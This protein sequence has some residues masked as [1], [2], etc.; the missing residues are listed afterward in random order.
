MKAR[1]KLDVRSFKS[2]QDS[3]RGQFILQ[4]WRC[5]D[6]TIQL[7][8]FDGNDVLDVSNFDTIYLSIR[9]LVD[10]KP[11]SGGEPALILKSTSDIDTTMTA[12][13]WERG[14]DQNAELSFAYDETSLNAG[15]YWISFWAVTEDNETITLGAGVCKINENG[16]ISTVPPDP[17]VMYYTAEETDDLLGNYA[18]KADVEEAFSSYYSKDEADARFE[19]IGGS[20]GSLDDYYTK[21]EADSRFEPLGGS[22]GALDNYYTKDETDSAISVFVGASLEDFYDKDETNSA[23]SDEVGSA[24]TNYYDKD[25]ADSRF[26]PIGG[27]GGV[28]PTSKGTIAI[29]DGSSTQILDAGTSNQVLV[30]DPSAIY[31]AK[32]GDYPWQ[33]IAKYDIDSNTDTITFEKIFNP[34]KFFHYKITC[35]FVRLNTV[36]NRLCMQYGYDSEGTTTWIDSKSEYNSSVADLAGTVAHYESYKW[37]HPFHPVGSDSTSYRNNGGDLYGEFDIWNSGS[38]SSWMHARCQMSS[39]RIYNG[40]LICVNG[41][42]SYHFKNEGQYSVNSVRF[43][44]FAVVTPSEGDPYYTYDNF[45]AG[46]FVVYGLP[47]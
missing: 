18:S 44:N 7:G 38:P 8:V 31:G 35:N 14:T 29:G 13:T 20:G 3:L 33:F 12:Q 28:S 25:Q 41:I 11:P 4:F 32:W 45:T 5:N 24:L 10:N 30:A 26:E 19:P 22:G 9:E 15:T 42:H 23:I 27:G 17:I 39:F 1:I 37:I 16:G 46:H 2:P 34:Q 6:W 43:K 21:E 36:S 40:N 47:R